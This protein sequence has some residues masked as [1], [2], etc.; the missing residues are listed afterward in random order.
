LLSKIDLSKLKYP[1]WPQ[2]KVSHVSDV[3]AFEQLYLPVTYL[4]LQVFKRNYR[5]CHQIDSCLR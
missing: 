5:E 3:V 2:R 1:L 4:A